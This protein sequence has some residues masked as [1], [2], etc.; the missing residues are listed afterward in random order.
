MVWRNRLVFI[1]QKSYAE[2]NEGGNF[3]ET[4]TLKINNFTVYPAEAAAFYANRNYIMW[5]PSVKY[6]AKKFREY[7]Y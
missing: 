4:Q 6:K 7:I 1:F 5:G 3:L 2:V